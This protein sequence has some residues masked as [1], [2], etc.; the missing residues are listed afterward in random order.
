VESS[1]Q[2][3]DDPVVENLTSIFYSAGYDWLITVFGPTIVIVE[4]DAIDEGT[5]QRIDGSELWVTPSHYAIDT[6]E[7]LMDGDSASYKRLHNDLDSG[8]QYVSGTY[9]G[10]SV[11]RITDGEEL[12]DTNDSSADF[13]VTPPIADCSN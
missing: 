4:A 8:F 12:I 5:S 11:R 6:M 3:K 13:Y 10:E 7:A 2:D 9:T 1:E